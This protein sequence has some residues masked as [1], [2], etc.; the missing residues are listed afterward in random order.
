MPTAQRPS[1]GPLPAN[2]AYTYAVE[3]SADE[4]IAIGAKT[5]R[6][7]Q[8]VINYL[9]NFL[10]FPVGMSVPTGYYDRHQGLWVPSDNGLVV[11]IVGVTGGLADLDSTGDGDADDTTALGV[12]SA[13]R[14][15]LA[16]LYPVG[17][18]LWRVP[19]AHFTPWDYNW[20]LGPPWDAIGPNG[21]P[22]WGDDPLDDPCLRS[23][24]IIECENQT[25]GEFLDI[26]GT[27]F[28]L[29]YRSDRVAGRVAAKSLR[30]PVSR[31]EMPASLDHIELEVTV[32]GQRI[33]PKLLPGA[34]R[35]RHC[36]SR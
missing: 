21:G 26:A 22:P 34:M 25:L 3:L 28:S 19:V 29:N 18:E 14:R 2:S 11:A 13:E 23:G 20:P 30:I 17:Q 33:G 32:A 9:E 10:A 15:Q 12:T 16:S 24:S 7:S 31:G 8:P 1:P 35:D 6:F 4:A 36:C 27:P 5:V